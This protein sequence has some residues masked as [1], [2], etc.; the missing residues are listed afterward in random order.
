MGE[1]GGIVSLIYAAEQGKVQRRAL[2]RKET[3]R[4]E[5][6][7]L[8]DVFDCRFMERPSCL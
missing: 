2:R 6:Y 4:H 1:V 5:F 7:V 8:T 3:G